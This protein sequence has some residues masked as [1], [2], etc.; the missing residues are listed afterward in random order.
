MSKEK[1]DL[2]LKIFALIIAIILWSYVMSEVNP[3][4]P[5]TIRN[6]PVAFNN[7]DA[8]ERQGLVLMEPKEANVTVRV[9]G[10]KF[11]MASFDSKSI[12]AYVDLSGYGE[13][14]IKVPV[15]V[16]IED[17]NNIRV[18]RIEPSEILFKFDRLISRQKPITIRTTGSLDSD[19]VLG[20]ITTKSASIL[21]TGPRSWVNE[22]A[23]VV[24]TV[25]L[26]GRKENTN[27]TVPVKLVDDEGEEVRGVKYEP[28][29][30]DVD[31]PVYRK[32]T[33]P[34]ELQTVNQL[35]EN[36]EITNISINP[37]RVALKG[38]N[39]I[40][41]LTSIQTKPIDINSLIENPT[42]EVELDLPANISL[43]NTNEKI[44]ITVNIEETLTKSFEFTLED[45]PIRNLG[46]GLRINDEDLSKTITVTA[47]GSKELMENLTEE[48]L[49]MYLDM[50]FLKE[51]EHRVQLSFNLPMGIIIEEVEPQPIDIR[52]ISD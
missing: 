34:I 21:I 30:I 5:E 28:T 6:I 2:T 40:S 43:V 49:D 39:S 52:L 36:Y 7:L 33:V 15:H 23:E 14:Q 17:F 45:I 25:D 18:E 42:M 48:D 8:L 31:I 26:S 37:S 3:D 1:N 38:A 20:D 9:N 27:L 16:V 47:K 35:P 13:G 10:R 24:A 22:V 46:E 50:N 12:K 41:Y 4:R 51:G 29:V 11:D 32:V 19:Y 44:T